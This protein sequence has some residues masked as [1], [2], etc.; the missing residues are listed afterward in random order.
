MARKPTRREQLFNEAIKRERDASR[1]VRRVEHNSG[2][3]LG[4]SEFDPRIKDPNVLRGMNGRE[5]RSHI[6]NL[7]KFIDRKNQFVSGFGGAPIPRQQWETYQRLESSFNE[8]VAQRENAI[9]DIKLPGSDTT[10]GQRL[11]MLADRSFGT[12]DSFRQF[13]QVHRNPTFLKDAASLDK[14]IKQLKDKNTGKYLKEGL[15]PRLNSLFALLENSGNEDFV[16]RVKKLSP[17]QQNLLIDY[18]NFSE[19]ARD[20]F[21]SGDDTSVTRED[22]AYY[23]RTGHSRELD[24]RDQLEAVIE[25]AG[26]VAPRRAKEFTDTNAQ[27]IPT[28]FSARNTRAGAIRIYNDTNAKPFPRQRGKK[29][30]SD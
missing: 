10:I 4:N 29:P 25:W 8:K 20:R 5:L 12:G 18:S 6:N 16:S 28:Q 17:E 22:Q 11:G 14:L 13:Q 15:T 19:I 24:I 27:P 21:S 7:N 9:R 30:N 23:E 2:A 3:K 26:Q 1:K